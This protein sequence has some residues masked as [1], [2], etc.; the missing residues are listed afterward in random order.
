MSEKIAILWFRKD[1]RLADNP[2]LNAAVEHG[3]VVPVYIWAPDEE[4]PWQPGGASRW[5][6]HQSLASLSLQLA[7]RNS[8]LILRCGPS[9]EMLQELIEATG[10]TTVYWNRRYEPAF[11]QRDKKI[12]QKL[13]GAGLTVE[14]FNGSLLFEPWEIET[15]QGDPYKVFTPF[16]KSCLAR[17]DNHEPLKAPKVLPAPDAWPES[18]ELDEWQLEPTIPWDD[19]M[20]EFWDVGTD[21]AN[22]QLKQFAKK[23]AADYEDQRNLMAEDGTSRLSPYLH[24]GEISPRQVWGAVQKAIEN[25]K[26][27][28][29]GAET[30]LSEIGWREFAYHLL[31]HFPD[32]TTEPLREKFASFPWSKSKKNLERWQ[33]GK[34]GYPVVDAA[35]RQLWHTGWMHN[36]ARMVVASFLCKHLLLPWQRGAE[37]FWDTLVDADLASNTLGWQ[38]T[39]GCGADAAPYFRIFN[40]MTQGEKFDPEGDYVRQW[41]PELAE[42]PNKWIYRPWEAPDEVLEEAGVTLGKDYP[43]PIVDHSEARQAALDAYDEIK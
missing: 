12:K 30:F 28:K 18:E 20:R 31:Y 14:S 38:W 40:P 39:A 4:K 34:T 7:E 25:D 16:W 1:L 13:Q 19:G 32:T 22:K 41:V 17:G 15:K 8:Q 33:R 43:K 11:V 5:W 36:R 2:A 23:S 26:S 37:W 29:E 3:R 24:F 42:L 6:L 10:A 9:L 27:T 21:A 35:M